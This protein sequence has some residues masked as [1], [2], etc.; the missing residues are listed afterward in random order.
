MLWLLLLLLPFLLG[1]C[2]A[3]YCICAIAKR[4]DE[5]IERMFADRKEKS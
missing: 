5:D 4:A 3:L 2:F 1:A